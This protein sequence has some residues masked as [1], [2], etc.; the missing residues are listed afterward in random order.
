LGGITGTPSVQAVVSQVIGGWPLRAPSSRMVDTPVKLDW[1]VAVVPT[2]IGVLGFTSMRTRT[3]SG[4][5]SHKTISLTCPTG[6]PVKETCDP[7]ARPDTEVLKKISYSSL[8]PWPSRA[9]QMTKAASAA[10]RTR[11]TT[12][13]Q[14]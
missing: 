2:R 14:T 5:F 4:S 6:T 11:V 7:V 1:M 3:N 8:S 12:P 10:R 9:S 13:T